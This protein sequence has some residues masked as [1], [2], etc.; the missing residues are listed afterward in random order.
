MAPRLLSGPDVLRIHLRSTAPLALLLASC[1]GMV[2]G[3]PAPPTG[4]T[5]RDGGATCDPVADAGTPPPL[6]E[7]PIPPE[8]VLRRIHLVLH[9]RPPLPEDQDALAAATTDAEREAVIARAIDE[10]LD[11]PDFYTR[12][13]DLGHHWMR[14]GS[15]STGAQGD[16]Y[17]GNMSTHL[18]R[19]GAE[20]V[21]AGAWIMVPDSG[22]D[23]G[24]A[25][26]DV[27][28]APRREVEPWWA[29]GTSVVLVGDAALETR[30]VVDAEGVTHDCGIALSGYYNMANARGC[31]CGPHAAWCYPGT[32][33]VPNP[34][35]GSQ[36][37]DMWDE[38]ARLVAHLAWHDRPLS[39]LVLGNYSV[40]NN[41]VRAWYLRFGRQTGIE[42]DR[43]DA[44]TTWFRAEVGDR[45]RDPLHPEP[46][47]PEAWREF[48]VEE[49]A[50]QLLS[51]SDRA[52]SADPSRTLRWDPRAET[53]PAPG[54]PAA[55]VLTMA[56][57]NSTFP[58]ERPRAARFLEIFAC[59]DFDPPPADQHFPPVSEDLATS[60]QCMHCH[61]L[62]DPVA[63]AFRR[64]I[65]MGTYVP[66]PRLADLA[67]LEVPQ[68]LYV[69]ARRYPNGRWFAAGADRWAQNWLPGTTMTP[70]TEEDLA[71][72]TGALFLDTIP[73]EYTIFGEHP[74]GT[75]GP[76]AFAKVLVSSGEFDRCAVRRIYE[77]VMGRP[78][79][80]AREGR[81]VDALARQFAADGRAVR[82][83]VR[84]LLE[85]PEM[86]RGL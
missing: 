79:D 56:G 80:P 73:P 30:E 72:N 77:R 66:L 35:P 2:G 41:R 53:G 40:G 57:T 74:D 71:R 7:E 81:Y 38:P 31:G 50:P 58:R 11:S 29:P 28:D 47:D 13:L 25:W 4:T 75:M 22:S 24:T 61:A 69:P 42:A 44:D 21:H 26:C 65:F 82:A 46:A 8:R 43:L 68:D 52:R 16:G 67:D 70:I 36:K 59:R 55:G 34:L 78:L 54:L 9:G 48:V 19:C 1:T 49:L 86:R 37:R 6:D 51:L 27:A 10:G 83:L 15:F 85:S 14:N 33:L 12:M 76:L 3:P 45:P 64:W 23:R 62:M 39:D 84:R 18:G 5:P 60:G 17:W 32:G 63:M 20:T